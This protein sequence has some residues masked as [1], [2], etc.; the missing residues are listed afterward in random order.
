MTGTELFAAWRDE[1]QV[2]SQEAQDALAVAI[3]AIH[4]AEATRDAAQAQQQLL[5]D[6][7]ARLRQPISSTL[8]AR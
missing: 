3:E 6:A 8:R 1:I 2:Q 7:V 5:R 4:E